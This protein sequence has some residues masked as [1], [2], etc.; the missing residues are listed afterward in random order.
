MIVCNRKGKHRLSVR[1]YLLPMFI[2]LTGVL[3]YAIIKV[4]QWDVWCIIMLGLALYGVKH[5]SKNIS[6]AH[7]LP[8]GVF[9]L[10]LFYLI[11]KY[12]N[13][14]WD[15]VLSIELKSV[16]HIFNWNDWFRSIPLNDGWLFRLWQ[17]D[18]LTAYM[19]WVYTY[20][21]ALS[22]WICVIRAFFTKDVKKMGLYSLAGYL[23]QVPFILPFYNTV[24]LQEVWY[25]LG[26]PDMLQRHATAAQQFAFTVNCFPS[27]HTSIAFSAILL[28]LREKSKW[29]R[30]IVIT[31]CSS[32]I[33][34]TLY[35]KIHWMIDVAAGMLFAYL[36]V[37]VAD[38]LVNSSVYES[39]MNKVESFGA[40]LQQTRLENRAPEVSGEELSS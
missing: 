27:M 7:F 21:F 5:D 16:H 3:F 14:M 24:F 4:D 35:L 37:K 38:F 28:V 11:Y 31:Y 26:T 40:S 39:M 12:A 33:L 22:F 10:A 32:I 18:W 23:L 19:R 36:C 15:H 6:W 25:V 30:T 17:P 8:V 1:N 2:L 9:V 13:P 34:S 29:Y 20:G